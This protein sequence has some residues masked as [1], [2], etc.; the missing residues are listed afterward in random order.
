[1]LGVADKA[2]EIPN[3]YEHSCR[4]AEPIGWAHP[5]AHGLSQLIEIRPR[6]RTGPLRWSPKPIPRR[7][8]AINEAD[9]C[10]GRLGHDTHVVFTPSSVKI[11][12]PSPG[13]GAWP[14]WM[15]E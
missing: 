5:L 4:E 3:P 13:P 11:I 12:V 14:T 8:T 7:R 1:M 9:N 2:V 10:P 6:G 15:Y